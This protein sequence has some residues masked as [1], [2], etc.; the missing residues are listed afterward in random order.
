MIPSMR[1][2]GVARFLSVMYHRVVDADE[3]GMAN[4]AQ[5]GSIVFFFMLGFVDFLGR[6]TFFREM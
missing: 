6:T 5:P 3:P 4:V 1:A 2:V